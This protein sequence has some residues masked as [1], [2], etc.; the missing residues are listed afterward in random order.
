MYY[1]YN[2]LDVWV[3][4]SPIGLSEAKRL[5]MEMVI[6]HEKPFKVRNTRGKLIVI[7]KFSKPKRRF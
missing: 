2:S 1:V 5:A 3:N 7:Y 6:E 4:H